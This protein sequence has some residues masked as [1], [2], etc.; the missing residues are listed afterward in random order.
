[1][2][3]NNQA[4]I[5]LLARE[6]YKENK[7]RNRILIGVIAFVVILLFSV[8]SLSVGKIETDYLLYMRNAG[9]A[10]YTTLE[11][12]TQEQSKA[13]S[14]LPYIKETGQMV[15][16]G[17]T[18]AFSCIVLDEDAYEKMQVP[19]YTD[20][21]GTY[22]EKEN[23]MM[24]PIRALSEM[25]IEKPNIGMK[26]PIEIE[27]DDGTAIE[28]SF[29]LSG[30]YTEYVDP[31]QSAPNGYFSKAFLDRLD[32]NLE[33]NTILLIQ[34]NDNIEYE[35]IESKLY[36]D[37]KMRDD[38]QQFFGGNA[39][40]YQSIYDLTGGFDTAIALTIIILIGAYLLLHNVLH[41]SLSREIK[42]YGLLKTLGTT[43]AQ[44]RRIVYRQVAKMVF[45]G[46]VIGAVAGSSITILIIP[47]LL[48]GMYLDGLGEASAMIAFKP[49][50]LL[51]AV[52]F[53][54][55]VTFG[56]TAMAM[57]KVVKMSPI[58]AAGFQEQVSG[59]RKKEIRST[60]GGAMAHMAWRNIFRF[61]KRFFV[62][63]LSLFLGITVSLAAVV[64]AKGTDQTNQIN[65]ENAD[66]RV[67]SNMAAP[68]AGEYGD[69]DVFFD[70]GLKK[71]ILELNGIT[72]ADVTHGG[73]GRV[74]VDEETLA[75]RFANWDFE[76]GTTSVPFVVQVLSDDYLKKLM[77]FAEK[78]NL[79]IDV[80]MVRNGEGV[81]VLHYHNLSKT[82]TE[83][84]KNTIGKPITI[85]N[86]DGQE[87]TKMPCGGYLDFKKKGLPKF[88]STWNGPSIIYFIASEKG[89]QKMGLVDRTFEIN[90]N[91]RSEVEPLVKTKLENM[92]KENNKK[93]ENQSLTGN[94]VDS[95]FLTMQAKSDIMESAKE[96]IVSSRIVMG[97]LCLILVV[98]GVVN[99][100]NV[101]MT[102]LLLRRKEF[103][104]MESIGLTRGQLRKMILMEGTY[105]SLI[106]S[107]TT[108]VLGSGLLLG[109][110][111]LMK[112]RIAYFTFS[113]PV[114]EFAI[115]I[116]LLFLICLAIPAVMF[117]KVVED[118]VIERLRNYNE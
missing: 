1:M 44:L 116:G 94:I 106:V 57:N 65:Y 39:M 75:M 16:I 78:E 51:F 35:S 64:I 48:S 98:M 110:S 29:V 107:V 33:E 47:K 21:H 81:I 77:N 38:Y 93:I 85:Y 72:N 25:N 113:Y 80:E 28:K 15:Y 46:C 43:K 109:L 67:L 105:Y 36:D 63:V 83:K 97:A 104:V 91:V 118:S 10:A 59:N 62:T 88:N 22:P 58:D 71:E 32:I 45:W 89:F 26:I 56:S 11:R 34:Q 37:V 103:A 42:R 4:I 54:A 114:M 90:F 79:Y 115:C 40:T 108:A 99:Y 69:D 8:F 53:G 101:M 30:Y 73:F 96:Y 82:M 31:A 60:T 13:I 14:A 68:M 100:F 52:I 117:R 41:I 19:A 66:F 102:S 20:I 18:D 70:P 84:S 24:L 23:E 61:R 9:T 27:L 55:V 17:Y 7:G 76:S 95:K 74:S 3:N 86:L 49:W 12:P 112:Q 5:T 6:G 87:T 2:K 50:I 111:S 92:V